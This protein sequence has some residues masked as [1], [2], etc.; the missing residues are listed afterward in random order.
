MDNLKLIMLSRYRQK[1]DFP[2]KDF[3]PK[4][5]TGFFYCAAG[6]NRIAVTPDQKIWGCFLFPE[7]GTRHKSDP[8]SREFCFGDLDDF[9]KNYREIYPQ[10]LA[11][12]QRLS[13]DNFKTPQMDC[14]LCPYLD[15]CGVCPVNVSFSGYPLGEIPE[16]VCRIH[17]I[18]IKMRDRFAEEIRKFQSY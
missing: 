10:V 12:Y 13:M 16:Y 9:S 17:K 3:R 15:K 2:L 1:G 7:Y 18:K 8:K 14:F 5:R 4:P 11:H 6:E